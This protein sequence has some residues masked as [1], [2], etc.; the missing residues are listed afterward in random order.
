LPKSH[1][2]IRWFALA[3]LLSFTAP[4]AVQAQQVASPASC[5]APGQQVFANVPNDYKLMSPSTRKAISALGLSAS[6]QN[7][8]ATV[9]C[10]ISGTGSDAAKTA[11]Q[12]CAVVTRALVLTVNGGAAVAARKAI[13]AKATKPTAGLVPGNVYVALQ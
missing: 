1:T 10:V 4:T 5:A 11:R 12:Q 8:T 3:S 9:T 6:K 13:S 2:L 7:C